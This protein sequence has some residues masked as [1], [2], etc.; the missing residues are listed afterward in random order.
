MTD[1]LTKDKRRQGHL[2][3]GEG[4]YYYYLEED[5]VKA[6]EGLKKAILTRDNFE[7]IPQMKADRI[8]IIQLIDEF[9][10]GGV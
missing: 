6:V 9:L 4:S 2:F 10:G 8:K 5:V 7:V 3:D 1:K